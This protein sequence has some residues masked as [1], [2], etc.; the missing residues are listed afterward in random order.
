MSLLKLMCV[1]NVNRLFGIEDIGH[2]Q[3]DVGII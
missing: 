1:Q 3:R 2:G